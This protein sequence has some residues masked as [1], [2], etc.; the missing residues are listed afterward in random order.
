MNEL[1][2]IM[3]VKNDAPRGL[4]Q[5]KIVA[6]EGYSKNKTNKRRIEK[7]KERKLNNEVFFHNSPPNN[8]Y[9]TLTRVVE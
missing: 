8:T 5:I 6:Y 3:Y 7:E 2:K 1:K 4:L 9:S